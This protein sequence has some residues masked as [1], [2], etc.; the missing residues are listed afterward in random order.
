MFLLRISKK[1]FH[2]AFVLA[3]SFL[4]KIFCQSTTQLFFCFRWPN[5]GCSVPAAY[6]LTAIGYSFSPFF[7][8]FAFLAALTFKLAN[9]CINTSMDCSCSAFLAAAAAFQIPSP[10]VF[11]FFFALLSDFV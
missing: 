11:K 3:F 7:D 4:R 5:I 1:H 10:P 9:S 6:A 2:M 8:G